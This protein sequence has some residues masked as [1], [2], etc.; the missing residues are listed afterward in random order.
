MIT[1]KHYS[2]PPKPSK[3]FNSSM[4]KLGEMMEIEGEQDYPEFNNHIL[5]RVYDRV[6]SLHNPKLTWNIS[7]A[8]PG[9]KLNPGNGVILIQE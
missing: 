4:L 1:K 5:L 2:K 9:R 8:F 6:I 7:V 3:K